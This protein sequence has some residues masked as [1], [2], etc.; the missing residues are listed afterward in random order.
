MSDWKSIESAP[1]DRYVLLGD[2]RFAE[3]AYLIGKWKEGL[4]WG[5]PTQS[6]RALIWSDAT[7]WMP[8]PELPEI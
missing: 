7:H 3:D 5:R 4:W 6:G 2:N 8:L 1:R